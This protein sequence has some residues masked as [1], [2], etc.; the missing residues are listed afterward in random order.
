M[1][2]LGKKTHYVHEPFNPNMR[3]SWL[4]TQVPAWYYHVPLRATSDPLIGSVDRTVALRYPMRQMFVP[5]PKRAALAAREGLAAQVARRHDRRAVVKDPLMLLSAEWFADR[6]QAPVVVTIRHPAAFASS[7]LR[8]GW[9]F[10]LSNWLRQPSLVEGLL[11]PFAED[12]S[13]RVS[14]GSDILG[15]AVLVWRVLHGVIAGYRER[16]PDWCFVRNEDLSDSPT[17]HFRDLYDRLGLTWTSEVATGV[18]RHTE[19]DN[20]TE[21]PLADF[22]RVDR[23]SRAAARTWQRRLTSDQVA[24]I[25]DESEPQSSLFYGPIDWCSDEITRV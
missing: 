21:L 19:T 11:A 5:S 9:T 25:R 13:A 24:R 6:Y 16:H 20:H 2:S 1:L 14:D 3:P 7:V 12:L 8:L 17:A 22:R 4:A 15:D 23:N 18:A 10:D